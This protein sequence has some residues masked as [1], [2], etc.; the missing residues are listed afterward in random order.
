M[1]RA[2]IDSL[3]NIHRA[4]PETYIPESDFLR[5]EQLVQVIV[6]FLFI[7]FFTVFLVL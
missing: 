5:A 2:G 1:V 6:F 4:I 7:F 3:S